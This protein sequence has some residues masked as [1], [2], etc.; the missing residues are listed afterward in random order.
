[1]IVTAGSM[2]N[3]QPSLASVRMQQNDR[4]NVRRLGR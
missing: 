1:M 3:A 2:R 4:P